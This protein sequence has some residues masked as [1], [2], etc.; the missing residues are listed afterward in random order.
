MYGLRAVRSRTRLP[1]T[2]GTYQETTGT[3]PDGPARG[4]RGAAGH[5][6]GLQG[7]VEPFAR[8]AISERSTAVTE[9][10]ESF[11]RPIPE[12]SGAEAEPPPAGPRPEERAERVYLELRTVLRELLKR[13]LGSAA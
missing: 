13:R 8:F 9:E 6:V 11:D 2:G 3:G 4:P 1:E 7:T 5:P 10:R 12:P